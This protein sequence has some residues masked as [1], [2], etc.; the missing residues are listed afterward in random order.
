V[1]ILSAAIGEGHDLPARVLEADV[2]AEAPGAQVEIVD[3]LDLLHP[4]LRCMALRGARAEG[5]LG[6]L[7]FDLNHW[8]IARFGPTRALTSRL[9]EAAAARR[10]RALVG[11][12]RPSVVVATYPGASEVLGRLRARGEL[13]V[14]VASAITDLASLD[15]W[16]HP[17]VDLHLITHPESEAEVRAIAP[18]ARVA[19]AR[20]MNLPDFLEP[21]DRVAARAALG[22]PR[23]GDVVVV[24]GGGW[25][26]GD[27]AGATEAVLA[28][29][30]ATAV[31]L[32]G[33]NPEVREQ[34]ERR[35]AGQSRVRVLGFTEQMPDVL[36]GAD[37][38]VHSTAGLTVLEARCQGCPVISYGWG[39]GHIRANNRAFERFGLARVAPDRPAL[40][41]ALREALARRDE[42][43]RSFASL[44]LAA[45][46]L[47]DLVDSGARADVA[48]AQQL[49][50]G[51]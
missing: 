15:Y 26:M 50:Q 44:P 8:L 2:R 28:L 27:L 5:V 43:D 51:G 30:G 24:S 11:R 32:T 7:L 12:W 38:L 25:A 41:A 18:G 37:A 19:A 1:L 16:A 10:M 33:R 45:R 9:I 29:G 17:G 20:G 22:L 46:L 40:A 21:R 3:S 23:E 47:L 48:P 36:A 42:P 39:K 14:P 4:L 13:E 49:A 35:Y 6:G 31:V 34:L